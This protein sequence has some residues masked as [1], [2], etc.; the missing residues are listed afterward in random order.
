MVDP[1]KLTRHQPL[2]LGLF[3]IVFGLLFASQGA[4]SV[5]GVLGRKAE[6]VGDWPYWYAGVI[7]VVC[8]VL[9]MVGI[10]TRSAAFLS[11]GAMAFAYFTVHQKDGLFPLQNGGESP[12]LYC[13]AFLLL[14]FTGPGALSLSG[15]LGARRR[16]AAP[17]PSASSI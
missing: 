13:W 10:G 17:E 16:A 1:S 5:F 2:A 12:A 14:V 9:I 15:L 4:A 11:S 7:E 3:R 6:E 8:G